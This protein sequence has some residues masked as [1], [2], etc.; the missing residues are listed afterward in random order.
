MSDT[1]AGQTN[2]L[3]GLLRRNART[4]AGQTAIREKRHG[5]WQ[6][7]TWAEHCDATLALARGLAVL[8]FGRGDRLAVL[9]DNRRVLY[10]AQLAAMALGGAV[11]PCWPDADA[12]WLVHVLADAGV[13]IVVAEDQDQVE[14]LLEIKDRLPA[15]R[16]I[17]FTDSRGVRHD[18]LTFIRSAADTVAAGTGSA[19]DIDASIAAGTG[20]DV[21]LICYLTPDAGPPRA[22]PL[23]HAHLIGAATALART[24][25][26]R[27]GDEYFAYLPMAW[28]AEAVY[29]TALSLLV[30]F[31]CS[32][33]EDPE[34]ARRDL[35]ELGPTILLAPP[36][37][38]QSLLSE[39]ESKAAH[40][41]PMKRRICAKFLPAAYS[42]DA[43][44]RGGFLAEWLVAAPLR[45]QLGLGNLRWAHTGGLTMAPH[46]QAFFTALGVNLGQEPAL[47]G[48]AGLAALVTDRPAPVSLAGGTET[49]ARPIES[50][51]C[52]NLYLADAVVI[53]T[54]DGQ[55][56][57]Q[58]G[59]LIAIDAAAVA[60][61]A[62]DRGLPFTTSADLM[63]LAEVRDLV[64]AQVEQGNASLPAGQRIARYRLLDT[65]PA[66][67]NAE[68]SLSRILQ[69]RLALESGAARAG[70]L[71][72]DPP[73]AGIEIVPAAASG[74]GERA[75]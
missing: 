67:S 43:P 14:K 48:H 46:V 27:P 37:I 69:R 39:I 75:A 71:F 50:A 35:R 66:A 29:G 62:Q 12:G 54:P 18:D 1:G 7:M 24:N 15:L 52:H 41:T 36:R 5:I 28:V 47:G 10:Q 44:A 70:D 23:T 11:V 19:L 74:L 51:L 49:D 20:N 58:L 60:D 31:A 61:W 22:V 16:Q 59:A 53:G 56:G 30:G 68:A 2:T 63:A 9:G 32:C 8:G 64:Q 73:G 38:W 17:V 57:A 45:D 65:L 34:T 13:S 55:P 26:V 21:C 40:A 4:L 33:P 25:D 42:A 6:A 72:A 3:P